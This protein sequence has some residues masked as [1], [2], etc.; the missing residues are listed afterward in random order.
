MTKPSQSNS[1]YEISNLQKLAL[2]AAAKAAEIHRNRLYQSHIVNTKSSR[3]DLV[4][5]V[6]LEAERTIIEMIE[7]ARPDDAI[8][9]EEGSSRTGTSGIR[10]IIDPLDGTTNYL[11]RYPG[12]T[13][14][15]GIEVNGRKTI[16]VVHDSYHQRIYTAVIGQLAFCNNKSVSVNE[17]VELADALIATGFMYNALYRSKQ[18]HSIAQIL[19]HIRDIRRSGSASL[20]L[21][22]LASGCIDGYFEYGVHP[23]DITAGGVIAAT[24]GAK[25]ASIPTHTEASTLLVASHPSIFDSLLHLLR[26]SNVFTSDDSEIEIWR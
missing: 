7:G 12:F 4:S 6:D 5:E 14:S 26:K 22:L 9:A 10:W 15:I 3:T 11:Y 21:C 13:V 23:W 18:A 25:V 16:G 17:S 2:E 24:A 8:V 1:R 19:P 20:D